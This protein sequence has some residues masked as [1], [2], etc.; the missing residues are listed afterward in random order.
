M[1]MKII[2]IKNIAP[3][4]IFVKFFLEIVNSLNLGSPVGWLQLS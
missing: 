2:F 1:V 4:S 3:S